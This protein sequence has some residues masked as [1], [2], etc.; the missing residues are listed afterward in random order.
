MIIIQVGIQ[1]SKLESAEE[2]SS[3]TAKGLQSILNFA[4]RIDEKDKEDREVAKEVQNKHDCSGGNT[5]FSEN[6]CD[7]SSEE[8]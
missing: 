4:S 3:L 8:R 1:M 7:K 6:H 5:E 2:G